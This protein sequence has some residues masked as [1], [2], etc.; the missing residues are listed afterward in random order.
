MKQSTLMSWAVLGNPASHEIN[1]LSSSNAVRTV[2][3][4][5]SESVK[6][7]HQMWGTLLTN[8]SPG[9]MLVMCTSSRQAIRLFKGSEV[10]LMVAS[11]IP[12]RT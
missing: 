12:V 10:I 3:H 1:Q 7:D 6:K 4:Y 9:L 11:Q 2:R 5:A 8:P